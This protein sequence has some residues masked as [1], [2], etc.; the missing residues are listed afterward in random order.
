MPTTPFPGARPGHHQ[1]P[2]QRPSCLERPRPDEVHVLFL[3]LD[4]LAAALAVRLLRCGV[5]GLNVNDTAP[6]TAADLGTGAYRPAD[7]GRPREAAL[8]RRLRELDPRCAPVS[9][10]E[11]FP[12]ALLPGTVVVHSLAL[13]AAPPVGRPLPGPVEADSWA[14]IDPRHPLVSLHRAGGVLLRW[15]TVAWAHRP[16]P[17]CVRATLEGREPGAAPH[18]PAAVLAAW[19]APAHAEAVAV[20]LAVEVLAVA[21]A[22]LCEDDDRGHGPAARE[23]GGARHA[24]LFVPPWPDA[25]S[26]PELDRSRCLCGL[27]QE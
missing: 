14:G 8:R 24:A 20:R 18:G 26:W 11:L 1:D 22:S 23:R 25:V 19:A 27:D 9:A 10:P 13:L 7:V 17:D 16:C 15:P 3:G 2:G 6:V 12:G 21:L 4:G 5:L